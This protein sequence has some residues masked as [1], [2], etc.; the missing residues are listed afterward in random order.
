[1]KSLTHSAFGRRARNCRLTRSSGHGAAL[2]LIVVLTGLPH[3]VAP[4]RHLDRLARQ[5][6]GLTIE[7]RVDGLS[8]PVTGALGLSGRVA[9]LAFLERP[10]ALFSR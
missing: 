4:E 1:M 5:L 7:Q 6:L 9:A 2:S 8:G 3:H 10:P